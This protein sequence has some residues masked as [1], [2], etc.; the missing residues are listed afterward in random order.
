MGIN[1]SMYI[2]V[3]QGK[4]ATCEIVLSDDKT[5]VK[6]GCVRNQSCQQVTSND[7]GAAL[8]AFRDALNKDYG[9]FGTR[10]FDECLGERLENKGVLLAGDVQAVV[11]N[12]DAQ[13]SQEETLRA[14][15]ENHPKFAE[16]LQLLTEKLQLQDESVRATH[17][18]SVKD[19]V[20]QTIRSAPGGIPATSTER[21]SLIKNV[22][23]DVANKLGLPSLDQPTT[24]VSS[25]G[26]QSEPPM[27]EPL[28][29][30]VETQ[31]AE[32]AAA[33]E[34]ARR[35]AEELNTAKETA[36]TV[37]SK[38][39]T[40]ITDSSNILQALKDAGAETTNDAAKQK[41]AE[42]GEKL[43]HLQES[44]QLALANLTTALQDQNVDKAT[45]ESTMAE[46]Q[47]AIPNLELATTEAQQAITD[48]E[49][50]RAAAEEAAR[51]AAEELNTAKETAG[52]VLSKA[53]TVI[54]DSSNIL[55]A[56]KDAG[57]ET[58]NDAAKQKLADAGEKL[59]HLQESAQLAL[60]NL[61]TA[62]QDQNVDKA[63][64]ESTMAEVQRA[65]PNLESAIV[66]ARYAITD[67]ELE[68]Q[69]AGITP[70]LEQAKILLSND[71]TTGD[72]HTLLLALTDR[73]QAQLATIRQQMTLNAT[74]RSPDEINQAMANL[75]A[76]AKIITTVHP[77]IESINVMKSR[78]AVAD[79]Q[80]LARM[81]AESSRREALALKV[82]FL[83][84]K[85]KF[86]A[87]PTVTPEDEPLPGLSLLL[88]GLRAQVQSELLLE[89][90]AVVRL[91]NHANDLQAAKD[92][93]LHKTKGIRHT[94]KQNFIEARKAARK[95]REDAR[96]I[97]LA[98]L[99]APLTEVDQAIQASAAALR[100][101]ANQTPDT[102]LLEK[103]RLLT[104]AVRAEIASAG[105]HQALAGTIKTSVVKVV[106]A[107]G[108]KSVDN[109]VNIDIYT[110]RGVVGAEV[111][112]FAAKANTLD[113]LAKSLE[114]VVAE[115]A[116]D[117]E[118]ERL[119]VVIANVRCAAAEAKAAEFESR[120]AVAKIEEATNFAIYDNEQGVGGGSGK[121]EAEYRY[122]VAQKTITVCR[123]LVEAE[124]Q[125]AA[126]WRTRIAQLTT[127][128]DATNAKLYLEYCNKAKA[129]YDAAITIE[130]E[131]NNVKPSSINNDI[132]NALFP[133]HAEAIL[134]AHTQIDG[135]LN[136]IKQLLTGF[137][138][139]YAADLADATIDAQRIAENLYSLFNQIEEA[140]NN[141][142]KVK[143]GKNLLSEK[144]S[145]VVTLAKLITQ[146][147]F[148]IRDADNVSKK[149]LTKIK[150]LEKPIYAANDIYNPA[151]NR[152]NS[153][154]SSTDTAEKETPE[155]RAALLSTAFT[156]RAIADEMRA[157]ATQLQEQC[158]EITRPI[159]DRI[160]SE[161]AALIAPNFATFTGRNASD[162]RRAQALLFDQFSETIAEMNKSVSR[163][164]SA[165][166]AADAALA[167]VYKARATK[168]S[169][170]TIQALMET[171]QQKLGD[172]QELRAKAKKVAEE[173]PDK[174]AQF[175]TEAYQTDE[176][177]K[178]KVQKITRGIAQAIEAQKSTQAQLATLI[179]NRAS[180]ETDEIE[181]RLQALQQELQKEI[182]PTA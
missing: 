82:E 72:A 155:A 84:V 32:R 23:E 171:V 16:K 123:H 169:A 136:G 80:S 143:L 125:V 110:K 25:E 98:P 26:Q 165:N 1:T 90:A 83:E 114:D 172:A 11:Q 104:L 50:A 57:A 148:A 134:N 33:E 8:Q 106:D 53:E 88:H 115:T 140:K 181:A 151:Q 35:A 43:N 59:N 139:Y 135:H 102:N 41:L 96:E 157:L 24:S 129:A 45:L 152:A 60:A 178:S 97:D 22:L 3:A 28:A 173:L 168:Q 133:K 163:L 64:L 176:N 47:R 117:E 160:T 61:T 17:K 138:L 49:A 7:N 124:Q 147:Q 107:N 120:L 146:A 52:T 144:A 128:S 54:T 13:K 101:A 51:R 137:N 44:A 62:L 29:S 58:T 21:E 20:F 78:A 67:L 122:Q 70:C 86:D 127:P 95:A 103:A 166:H 12:L 40:V 19:F 68:T 18:E 159:A 39:E 132:E 170:E 182:N 118:K 174:L 116:S 177:S 27:P 15:I 131:I 81:D 9:I 121:H 76:I 100:E 119:N 85:K 94:T 2:N 158:A 55:Q 108:Q 42:A 162:Y 77:V 48:F 38:A 161:A 91:L 145:E 14:E 31:E 74:E 126:A 75:N 164:E 37:L 142:L 92:A 180:T 175:S 89:G 5:Q 34:A 6:T 109:K 167:A 154:V 141:L 130:N 156:A 87:L 69:I 79:D 153:K 30:D 150:T 112:A 10:A 111:E 149:V 105:L 36:G 73:A 113:E 179:T 66:E 71:S 93:E 63:T 4:E 65:I 56:L 46:V 99:L